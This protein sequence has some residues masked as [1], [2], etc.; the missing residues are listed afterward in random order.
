[1]ILNSR[2]LEKAV[3][4]GLVQ[5]YVDLDTQL[6]PSGFDLTAG[7][8]H[9]YEAK[10][11]LDFSN[12]ERNV[13]D[14]EKIEP[15]KREDGDEYGWWRLEPGVYKV[16]MNEKVDIPDDVVG[17]A[18]PRSSLLRMGCSIDNAVWDP[19]FTGTGS[20]MITVGNEEGVEIKEKARVNQIV[21]H[22]IDE[23]EGYEGVYHES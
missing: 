9:R 13:P 1:M 23:T 6:Q 15:E 19:G 3:E 17:F 7:E 11:S 18:Y 5:N 8:I 14:T 10:G 4:N 21:F 20:F 2:Q 22:T 16:V 12:S